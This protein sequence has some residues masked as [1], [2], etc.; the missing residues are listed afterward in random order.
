MHILHL[1]NQRGGRKERVDEMGRKR[2]GWRE[3]IVVLTCLSPL[4]NG[5]LYNL[6]VCV[7]KKIPAFSAWLSV[8]YMSFR[9]KIIHLE[10]LV[11]SCQE[12]HPGK[13]CIGVF[14]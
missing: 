14:G 13:H 7:L 12:R 1:A 11:F 5:I 6:C 10:P 4:W 2:E 3:C 9:V 8:P